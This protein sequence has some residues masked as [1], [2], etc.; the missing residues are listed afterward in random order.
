MQPI[1]I[2]EPPGR[3]EEGATNHWFS[4]LYRELFPPLYGYIRFRVGDVHVAEELTARVFERALKGLAS[5][6][7]PERVRG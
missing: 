3:A 5:V 7:E 2:G 6:R 4:D 1:M